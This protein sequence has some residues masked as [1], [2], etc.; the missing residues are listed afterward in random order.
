MAASLA[1][2]QVAARARMLSLAETMPFRKQTQ[3]DGTP[4]EQ[5][6][7]FVVYEQ[8]GE[9]GMAYVHRAEMIGRDG[10]RKTVALKRMRTQWTDDPDFIQAFVHEA[11]LASRLTHPNIAQAYDLGKIDG[12]Y[13]IA[14][15]LVPGPTLAQIIAQSRRAAGPIPL[16][17]AME[18][19]IQ[20][21][22]ALDHAHDLRDA[23][24]R[25]LDLVH[26]DISPSNVIVSRDG[27]AKLIDFGIAK[28]RSARRATQA[29]IIKGKHAYVAPEY[30]YGQL[31]RRADLW[32]LGVIAHELLTGRRLFVGEND[33]ATIRNV[34]AQ[35][36]KPPSHDAPHIPVDLDDIVMTALQRDP[37]QRWQNAGAMRVALT[38][39]ARRMRIAVSTAQIRDWVEWAF[40]Q[41][42]R[43]ETTLDNVLDTLDPSISIV[44]AD[45]EPPSGKRPIDPTAVVRWEAPA[46]GS[47]PVKAEP[48]EAPTVPHKMRR[49]T[50][51]PV[52]GAAVV[53]QRVVA[54]APV[55]AHV[56]LRN[57]PVRNTPS[58]ATPMRG[59]PHERAARWNP[60]TRW[61]REPRKTSASPFVLLALLAFAALAVANGWIDIEA[62]RA[63]L[64]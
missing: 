50:P 56:L 6:G 22:D 49:T 4:C 52:I 42:P 31:D 3:D 8:L 40:R 13:Y 47:S 36:I 60:P 41:V 28:A 43:A 33:A 26:R 37:E 63:L 21:C 19:L 15:E 48:G 51:A 27:I 53:A 1:R 46:I 64:A 7:P 11:Q 24:G 23:A 61:T 30:T 45:L 44:S 2:V 55:T 57:A 54:P 39:E 38:T 58:R 32:G 35:P 12:T 5:F 17:I 18:I 34:R 14:M 62:W 29:G 10:F 59:T 9:G 20:L 16:P 25:P